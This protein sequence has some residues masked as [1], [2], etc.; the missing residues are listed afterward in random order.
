MRERYRNTAIMI[1][2]AV[3]LFV[4]LFM[5]IHFIRIEERAT[6]SRGFVLDNAGRPVEI[7]WQIGKGYRLPTPEERD[8]RSETIQNDPEFPELLK[9]REAIAKAEGRG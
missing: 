6:I 1:G 9:A 4:W 8:Q 7:I 2:A 3:T 5:L